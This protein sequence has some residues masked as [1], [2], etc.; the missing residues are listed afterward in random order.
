MNRPRR[1][2]PGLAAIEAL[3]D[4]PEVIVE[5]V[6]GH[7]AKPPW[8]RRRRASSSTVSSHK[9]IEATTHHQAQF[10]PARAA[11]HRWGTRRRRRRRV[12]PSLPRRAAGASGRAHAARKGRSARRMSCGWSVEA[13]PGT[14]RVTAQRA[15][16]QFAN[17]A[18]EGVT[19]SSGSGSSPGLA[20]PSTTG[21][22]PPAR[23]V[24]GASW[25]GRARRRRPAPRHR[26]SAPHPH[27]PAQAAAPP[28]R[29]W[30]TARR[31]TRPAASIS[32]R[33]RT[34]ASSIRFNGP[35]RPSGSGSS[36][37][38]PSCPAWRPSPAGS[39]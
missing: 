33:Q 26:S 30:P 32:R 13:T 7:R 4:A 39:R 18:V 5:A 31:R 20:S 16:G 3:H 27:R 28:A 38:R 36:P 9:S 23:F 1:C 24:L 15:D 14:R 19:P 35:A 11:A 29:G 10:E 21:S 25:P 22:S 37:R 34:S 6:R 2:C 17:S 12:R 8:L